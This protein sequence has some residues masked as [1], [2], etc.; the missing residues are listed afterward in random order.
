MLAWYDEP[1]ELLTEAVSSAAVIAD[2]ILVV[3]GAYEQTPGAKPRSPR[4]QADAIRSAARAAGM[5]CTIVTP[6]TVWA[7]QV[8][9]RDFMIKEAALDADWVFTID[10]DWVMT[11]DR[12]AIRSELEA[13]DVDE[14]EVQLSEPLNPDRYLGS[15]PTHSWHKE[16]AGQTEWMAVIYRALP[17]IRCELAHWVFSA[18]KDGERIGLW[19]GRSYYPPA[20]TARL[21]ADCL[22]EHR[23]LFRRDRELERNVAYCAARE[24]QM[25]LMAGIEL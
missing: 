5:Q 24:A 19:G 15:I 4:V 23:C 21:K 1:L 9:K 6:E 14:F 18:L 11:G 22:I 7:G 16:Y 25:D 12:D 20:V 13:S 2:R 10:A 17:G 3:D 8:A